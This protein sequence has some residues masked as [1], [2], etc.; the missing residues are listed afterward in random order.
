MHCWIFPGSELESFA[1]IRLRLERL[2]WKNIRWFT[3]HVLCWPSLLAVL[4]KENQHHCLATKAK[5][6][7][8]KKHGKTKHMHT[9]KTIVAEEWHLQIL[10]KE[11]LFRSSFSMKSSPLRLMNRRENVKKELEKA[12]KFRP[13]VNSSDQLS[14]H[15]LRFPTAPP[16]LRS[17]NQTFATRSSCFDLWHS[18]TVLKH[19]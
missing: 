15:L 6:G 14:G 16:A 9:E 7:L 2:G 3:K 18:T 13:S 12:M 11:I 10:L 8:G 17:L 19:I 5:L 1:G 4:Q